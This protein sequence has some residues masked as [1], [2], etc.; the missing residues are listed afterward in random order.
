MPVTI[1]HIAQ[2][3]GV[4]KQAVSCALN[5]K[6]G[7]VSEATR[8]RVIDAARQMGYRP[9]FRARSFARQRS[10]VIGLVYGRPAEYVENSQMV[11]SLVEHLA[12][13]NYELMLIPAVG[14]IARWADKL[15]DGRV[16]GALITHPMP[17]GLDEFVAEHRL[18]AVFMN[19]RSD[20]DVPQVV[21]DDAQGIELAMRHLQALGHRRITY[22]CSPKSHGSH[23]SNADRRDAY[24]ATMVQMGLEADLEIVTTPTPALAHALASTPP[25]DR[26]TA[27]LAYNDIDA[28]QL[29][30]ALADQGL[31]VPD[32]LSLVGF[33]N[34]FVGQV[35][36]PSLTSIAVPGDRLAMTGMR[37]LLD[38]LSEG[39][40][41][42]PSPRV[43][44]PTSLIPRESSRPIHD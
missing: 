43:V 34:T 33:N 39:E 30:R 35:F 22:F 37:L 27:V 19:L 3:V 9:N 5:N 36:L 10:Q 21:F 25:A 29:M 44:L 32:D 28:I 14:P 24:A 15:R 41:T 1:Q 23:Y 17:L 8:Q 7:Q 13:L 26:P 18:P 4:S 42:T 2:R 20:L 12:T 38:Q 11:S 6:T 31:K 16:D 40:P